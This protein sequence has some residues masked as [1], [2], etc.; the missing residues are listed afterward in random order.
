MKLRVLCKKR[1]AFVVATMFLSM[2]S[3]GL[4]GNYDLLNSKADIITTNVNNSQYDELQLSNGFGTIKLNG[5]GV[6]SSKTK[7]LVID[8]ENEFVNGKSYKLDKD[9]YLE[10]QVK[11]SKMSPTVIKAS[12]SEYMANKHNYSRFNVPFTSNSSSVDV[13]VRGK[14]KLSDAKIKF[15]LYEY[16][17]ITN[18]LVETNEY[19]KVGK[20][21]EIETFVVSSDDNNTYKSVLGKDEKRFALRPIT[22]DKTVK[23]YFGSDDSNRVYNRDNKIKVRYFSSP[24]VYENIQHDYKKYKAKYSMDDYREID[25]YVGNGYST[26]ELPVYTTDGFVEVTAKD[27]NNYLLNVKAEG[28]RN[29]VIIPI[30]P[31][32][33]VNEEVKLEK[34]K[35]SLERIYSDDRYSTSLSLSKKAFN[36]AKYAVVASGNNFAD[37]LSGGS[38]AS[39]LG[40][41]L[42]LV[43]DSKSITSSVKNELNRLGVENVIILG[44]E[45]SVSK[46]TEIELAQNIKSIRL[47]GSNRY[48]TSISIYNYITNIGVD[49]E[50]ILVNGNSFADALSAGPLS[51]KK[52]MPIILTDGKTVNSRLNRTGNIVIGGYNS[53]SSNFKGLRVAGSDR[54]ETSA[55]IANKYF[56]GN[57]TVLVA[58]GEKYPDGLSS[59]SLYSKYSAP[60][61]LTSYDGV[62][63]PVMKY[64]K[65]NKVSNIKVIGGESSISRYAFGALSNY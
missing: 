29:T 42:L 25:L 9:S 15:N 21:N 19:Y 36:S 52:S 28:I 55:V 30:K 18:E 10:I 31:E 38:L 62:P 1:V 7:L 59:I 32:K 5:L 58:S 45:K 6:N 11:D 13:E 49:H 60:L 20:V 37:A 8:I 63:M 61:L 54:F 3:I 14:G 43:N 2:T 50:V 64:L 53:M 27:F 4:L 56:A 44:G 65:D 33:I 16:G 47:A 24:S 46:G 17:V 34:V 41:P 57:P 12:M 35:P 40:A 22:L 23:F 48:E 51:A 39:K 26:V